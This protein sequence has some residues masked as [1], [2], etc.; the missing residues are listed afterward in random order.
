MK[1]ESK[2]SIRSSSGIS[3]VSVLVAVGIAGILAVALS[4]LM[5]DN[6]NAQRNIELRSDAETIKRTVLT[7]MDCAETLG[8]ANPSASD[9]NTVCS[10]PISLKRANGTVIGGYG[11][12]EKIGKYNVWAECDPATG[13]NK[14]Q[15]LKISIAR[16]RGACS[17][18]TILLNPLTKKPDQKDDLFDGVSDF[19][20]D[21]MAPK[22]A[23]TAC[24]NPYPIEVDYNSARNKPVCC[25]YADRVQPSAGTGVAARCSTSESVRS[26]GGWCYVN[27]SLNN[28][29]GASLGPEPSWSRSG[30][31]H[32]S[33]VTYSSTAGDGWHVDCYSPTSANDTRAYAYA[34]CCPRN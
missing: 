23:S 18:T 17:P 11:A 6:N 20:R 4:Q 10:G 19:C 26:G 31:L 13:T 8:F 16:C 32:A 1:H 5:T 30:F 12:S 2:F 9:L 7:Q 22:T 3:L 28:L 33:N 21:I 14:N 15:E 24:A 34:V 25:R 27:G 29:F